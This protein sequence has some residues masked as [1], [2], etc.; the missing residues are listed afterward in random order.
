MFDHLYHD[1]TRVYKAHQ[2]LP[3]TTHPCTAACTQS[4]QPQTQPA[5]Q[6]ML[7]HLVQLVKHAG[8]SCCCCSHGSILSCWGDHSPLL[9]WRVWPVRPNRGCSTL[10]PLLSPSLPACLQSGIPFPPLCPQLQLLL[11]HLPLPRIAC[12]PWTE[13]QIIKT[14]AAH[15]SRHV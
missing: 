3:T 1:K 10:A 4:V 6:V 15:P 14:A 9:L 13:S 8:C 11:L 5:S 12:K 2:L 7:H